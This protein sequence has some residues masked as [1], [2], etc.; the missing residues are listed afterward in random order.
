MKHQDKSK[1]KEHGKE[2]VRRTVPQA[3][4]ASCYYL[5]KLLFALSYGLDM[6]YL[7]YRK[8]MRDM[9]IVIENERELKGEM[10]LNLPADLPADKRMDGF[11]QA[12][13]TYEYG[14]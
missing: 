5:T 11:A 3:I 10:S 13:T 8:L 4:I 2:R 12:L 9:R 6:G 7:H 1:D 14:Q